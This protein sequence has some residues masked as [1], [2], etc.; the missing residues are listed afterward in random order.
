MGLLGGSIIGEIEMTTATINW[1]RVSDRPV[2]C[3]VEHRGLKT[4]TVYVGDKRIKAPN[5]VV[6]LDNGYYHDRPHIVS[7]S[8][9][10][11][12][13]YTV[14]M[15]QV[16]GRFGLSNE[17]FTGDSFTEALGKAKKKGALDIQRVF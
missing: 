2:H 7:E 11:E 8:P 4:S 13:D 10:I 15:G 16:C 14:L 5:N 17:V 1:V 9:G 12:K 6:Q 3:V